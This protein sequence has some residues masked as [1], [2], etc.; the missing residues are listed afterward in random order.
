MDSKRN[1]I[2]TR[3]AALEKA[4]NNNKKYIKDNNI[5]FRAI[6]AVANAYHK[7]KKVNDELWD[8]QNVEGKK[9]TPA[10]IKA[11]TEEFNKLLAD[12]NHKQE[13]T[14]RYVKQLDMELAMLQTQLNLA[15]QT[16]ANQIALL[17]K[18]FA[19][20]TRLGNVKAADNV[21]KKILEARDKL[22]SIVDSWITEISSKYDTVQSYFDAVPVT[23]LQR[24]RGNAE[25]KSYKNAELAKH[26]R[27]ALT[28]LKGNYQDT[29]EKIYANKQRQEF[30][31]ARNLGISSTS[32]EYK[33]NKEE[34][35]E[36]IAE[37]ELLIEQQQSVLGKLDSIQHKMYIAEELSRYPSLLND[38][39][40]TSK[41]ALEDG[42][43][44]FLT[45]GVT[46][47]KNLSEAL[48][49]L[50]LDFVKTMQKM[51]AKRFVT[52]LMQYWFPAK[53]H[54]GERTS[55]DGMS[56]GI[57]N[58]ATRE[59]VTSENKPVVNGASVEFPKL[60]TL[61]VRNKDKLTFN[62]TQEGEIDTSKG[63]MLATYKG[64]NNEPYIGKDKNYDFLNKD[65]DYKIEAPTFKQGAYEYRLLSS[66]ELKTKLDNNVAPI[67]TDVKV[68]DKE[69][70]TIDAQQQVA[71]NTSQMLTVLRSIDNAVNNKNT[72]TNTSKAPTDVKVTN[73]ESISPTANTKAV[74]DSLEKVAGS[75]ESAS[76]ANKSFAISS[77]RASSSAQSVTMANQTATTAT[78][79]RATAEMGATVTTDMH[80][81]ATVSD[82]NAIQQHAASTNM[83]SQTAP[84][85]GGMMGAGASTLFY[86]PGAVG[87]VP[88]GM[89]TG[90]VGA[91]LGNGLSSVL[92]PV[93]NMV[94]KLT[95]QLAGFLN[96]GV[97]T[98]LMNSVTSITGSAGAQ[99][100]GSAL[101]IGGLI[102][103]DK[104]EQLLSTIFLELQLIYFQIMQLNNQVKLIGMSI[105]S[106]TD[107]AYATGGKITGPG[108]GTSDSIPA[109]LSNGEYVIKASSVKKY[110]TNFLDSVNSGK[111]SRIPVHVPKF[112][113]GGAIDTSRQEVGTG[114]QTFGQSLSNNISNKAT[115][116]V[117][118]VRDEQEG[119][120]Q[121]LR[122]PEGQ[123]IMLDFQKQYASVTRRF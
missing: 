65:T 32:S 16:P 96:S 107:S 87:G 14:D 8:M 78:S 98:S 33:N 40:D 93:T 7:W 12:Y 5:D 58:V 117:A 22:F 76:I 11:K 54:E 68:D 83:A 123:R 103:G 80:K 51:F 38:I 79:Q 86:A 112:A 72:V 28:T 39:R 24:E 69:V 48:R 55:V 23:N 71:N 47:A 67:S 29:A 118:L 30:L 116:N 94:S 17:T 88:Y 63:G 70:T 4:H 108:T 41:Q 20:Y 44:T 9:G 27:S 90:G 6:R 46:E 43:V 25:L 110:G 101:A 100:G 74:N 31:K 115:F 105:T 66:D 122:S 35:Q 81:S 91:T 92:Q 111:L 1:P 42:L 104:K 57:S 60:K 26:Y 106:V 85:T 21:R 36:L 13:N 75:A 37:R 120:K 53:T 19:R 10:Q 99:L 97:F 73:A 102:S 56:K 89:Q 82:I 62:M 15:K 52:D 50:I 34:I 114:M 121:L 61:D 49:T 18:E 77:N 3:I 95:N 64:Y 113:D 119:M 59:V 2:I 84:M 109:M 45:E